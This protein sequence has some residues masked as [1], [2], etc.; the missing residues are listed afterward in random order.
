MREEEG[1]NNDRRTSL[2]APVGVNH[3]WEEGM[4]EWKRGKEG[5][6]V[7]GWKRGKEGG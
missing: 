7:R 3:E 2:I 6:W 4:G 5:E 1:G